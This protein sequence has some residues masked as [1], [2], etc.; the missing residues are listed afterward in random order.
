MAIQIDSL[1][2]RAQ[3]ILQDTTGVRWPSAELVDWLNDGQREVVMLHPQAGAVTENFPLDA[4][5]SLQRIPTD[6]MQ[7]LRVIRNVG[8]RAIREV[9]RDILDSQV[10]TWHTETGD[11][12]L[13]Y[14]HDPV[15]Q[16]VFY[17]YPR[18][19]GQIELVYAKAPTFADSGG[20]LSIADVYA[21]AVLDY[22]LYRAYSKD[23]EATANMQLAEAHLK[24]FVESL[25][26]KMTVDAG[27]A[28]QSGIRRASPV[29]S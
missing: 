7:F 1:V 16:R 11:A 20:A 27:L 4:T 22:I 15:D 10:P 19:A 8:G 17:V 29:G 6:G 13:H 18:A 23:A 3:T 28:Y 5:D 12:V 24:R 9:D 25:G 14:V 21:N 2:L 26:M